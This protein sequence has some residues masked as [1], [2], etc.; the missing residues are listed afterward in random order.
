M[1]EVAV[2]WSSRI[3]TGV[4]GSG[5][6]GLFEGEGQILPPSC[7]Y[8]KW[9]FGLIQAVMFLWL[10]FWHSKVW[11]SFGPTVAVLMQV[12]LRTMSC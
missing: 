3:A 2:T 5:L 4:P 1:R 6:E 12:V 7:L 9:D 8:R 11:D 10:P